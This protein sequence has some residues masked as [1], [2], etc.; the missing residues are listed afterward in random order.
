MKPTG[1][2]LPDDGLIARGEALLAS[3]TAVVSARLVLDP[4]KGPHVHVLTTAE[5]PVSEVSRTVMSALVLGMGF[6]VRA[7]QITVV[8]SRLS[9]RELQGLLGLEAADPEPAPVLPEEPATGPPHAN[10]DSEGSESSLGGSAAVAER[11]PETKRW[12]ETNRSSETKRSPE[13]KPSPEKPSPEVKRSPE[14]AG[15][16]ESQRLPEKR[17]AEPDLQRLALRDLQLKKSPDGGFDILVRLT[18]SDRSIGAQRDADGTE[19]DSLEVPASAALGVIQEFLR[20]GRGDGLPVMLRFLA[21]QHVRSSAHDV[22]VVLVEAEVGDRRIPLTGAA[23]ADQGVE[24]ASILA[25]LQATN[26]FVA[27]TLTAEPANGTSGGTSA[28]ASAR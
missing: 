21:A 7:D 19:E 1:D 13:T 23:S 25:T 6:E 26:A 12:P 14:T 2:R 8:H 11:V 28:G 5:T 3:L 17:S 18:S 15:V 22:V 24:R 20:S 16:P 9:R 27:G 4:K 10:A